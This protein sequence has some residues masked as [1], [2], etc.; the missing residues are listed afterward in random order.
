MHLLGDGEPYTDSDGDQHWDDNETY[1]DAN[2][3]GQYDTGEPFT[4]TDGD[5]KRD[6]KEPFV[7]MNGSGVCDPPL[8]VTD[9]ASEMGG[10]ANL[11][12]NYEGMP[13]NISALIPSAPTTT[14]GGET[15]QSLQAKLRVKHGRVDISAPPGAAPHSRR[16]STAPT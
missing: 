16:R 8:T 4:D 10:D 11:G 15:V 1:I 7:D 13:S 5:G 9:M 14:F 12:N 3:N 2:G 6:A